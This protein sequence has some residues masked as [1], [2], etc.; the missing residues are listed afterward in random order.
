MKLADL[1]PGDRIMLDG[2][3]TCVDAGPA[4]VRQDKDGHLYFRCAQGRHYLNGQID[5]AGELSGI[6]RAGGGDG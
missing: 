1:A 3:F 5:T 6:S 4:V 2:G